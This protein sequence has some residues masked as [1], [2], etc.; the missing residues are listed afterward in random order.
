MRKHTFKIAFD[1]QEGAM[2]RLLGLVQRRG[3]SIE[4]MDM[5]HAE[6]ETKTITLTVKPLTAS[7]RAD[8]LQRQI[9]R[10]QEVRDVRIVLPKAP[11]RMPEF[12][13]RPMAHFQQTL[14]VQEQ[15][16]CL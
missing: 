6:G 11:R 4:S 5:P 10:L 14:F 8:V 12:L 13:S 15:D 16:A 7:H 2:M 3:F 9:E 1:G